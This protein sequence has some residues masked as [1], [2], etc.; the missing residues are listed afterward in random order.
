MTRE[1][2]RDLPIEN[3]TAVANNNKADLLVSLH[4]NASFRPDTTGATVYVASFNET[5]LATEGLT[6]ER[7]PVFG[8]GLRTIEIVPWNLAQIPHRDQSDQFAQAVVGSLQGRVAVAP[9]GIEHAPLRVLESANMPAVLLEMGYLSN[10]DQEKALATPDAQ[11]A[12]TAALVDAIVKF[13]DATGG[14][15][16]A[17]AR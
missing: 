1:D 7:M 2:D 13:R 9:R 3:R 11:N 15:S 17:A 10:A 16:E 14:G 12:I 5:Q 4:A 8:G 6:G